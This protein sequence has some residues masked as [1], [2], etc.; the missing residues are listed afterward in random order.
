LT[1]RRQVAVTIETATT[2][3]PKLAATIETS[4]SIRNPCN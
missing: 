3:K 2:I 4:P 1:F